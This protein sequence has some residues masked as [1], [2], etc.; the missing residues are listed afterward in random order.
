MEVVMAEEEITVAVDTDV[1]IE[2]T[3]VSIYICL[4]HCRKPPPKR[5]GGDE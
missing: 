1:H 2:G 3:I 5:M 4:S